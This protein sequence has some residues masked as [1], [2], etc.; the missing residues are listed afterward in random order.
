M[1]ISILYARFP[2]RKENKHMHCTRK[3]LDDLIWVGADDRRLA[4]SAGRQIADA[5]DGATE[6]MLFDKGV[7]I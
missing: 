7:I 1:V 6:F 2:G 4:C 5:D 3:I